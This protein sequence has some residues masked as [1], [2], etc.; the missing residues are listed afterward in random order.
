LKHESELED[1]CLDYI[2]HNI[3]FVCMYEI[4]IE[5]EREREKR[6]KDKVLLY[7]RG[8]PY[9]IEAGLSLLMLVL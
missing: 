2:A 7:K 1:A 6:E 8:T 4:E 5:R 3:V 9:I